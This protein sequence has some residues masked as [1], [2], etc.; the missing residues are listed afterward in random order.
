MKK[1]GLIIAFLITIA[2]EDFF[3]F[4]MM[5]L[6]CL[7]LKYVGAIL[8]IIVAID[9]AITVLLFRKNYI[10]TLRLLGLVI[11][12]FT[13]NVL[14]LGSYVMYST[15]VTLDDISKQKDHYEQYDVVVLKD[16]QYQKV[17]DING[18]KVYAFKANSKMYDEAMQ[19]LTVKEDVQYDMQ[20]DCDAVARKLVTHKGKTHDTI[21]FIPDNNYQVLCEEDKKFKKNTEILY[22]VEVI[23]KSSDNADRV[24][25]TED[26][27]NICIT[28]IDMWGNI[29]QVSRSD[30]NMIM[31]IN[32]ETRTI[33]L[34]SMP[35]DSYVVLH[36]FGQYDKLTHTGVW[37][38]EETMSTI[39]DWL[40]VDLNYYVRVDF[41]MLVHIVHE[42]GGIDVYSDYDFDS[43]ISDHFYKKGWNHLYGMGALYFARERK[44]FPNQDQQRII[45]QQR[46]MK[47]CLRK[48]MK[49]ETLL[50]SYTSL[51]K[52]VD[53]EMET[54]LS[55]KE[56]ASLVRMQLDDMRGWKMVTQSVQG[57]LTMKGTYTMGMDRDLLVSIPR[58]KS[59]EKVKKK[60]K[61]I[62]YPMEDGTN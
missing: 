14:L 29:D 61:K 56:M 36:S 8:A 16:S 52:V 10:T 43:S 54:N 47:A 22:S 60:I 42:I 30:V 27:F 59:V 51:L 12:A 19:K 55:Q 4:I 6:D 28:G 18:H 17:K 45:N 23:K 37:G 33:L 49:S 62:M 2:A 53:G 7:P 11:V 41:S 46:V 9:V 38:T 32:P 39:E 58:E 44:A 26:P 20:K 34:T 31:T 48:V 57:D 50:T 24:N 21:T 35:R 5:A 25:V 15:Y 13:M 1:T 40:D 3:I